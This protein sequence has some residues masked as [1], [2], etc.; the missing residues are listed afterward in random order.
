[1][2]IHTEFNGDVAA[3]H[4]AFMYLLPGT[5]YIECTSIETANAIFLIHH[6][7]S[8]RNGGINLNKM[9]ALKCRTLSAMC[10]RTLENAKYSK[11]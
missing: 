10:V 8:F 1:M 11:C 3:R 4:C 2:Y 5:N 9:N 7:N 6:D